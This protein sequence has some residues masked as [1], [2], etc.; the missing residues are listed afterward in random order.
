MV[1]FLFD[2]D[3][4]VTARE[5]LPMIAE[6]YGLMDEVEDLTRLAVMGG[7]PFGE[8]FARRVAVLGRLPVDQVRALVARVPLHELV[9]D[10]ITTH[11]ES[12]AIVTSNLD[13][14]CSGLIGRLGC[15]AHCSEALV[16]HNRVEAIAHILNK[17]DVIEAYQSA[18]DTVVFVGDGHNDRAAMSR[19]DLAVAVGLLPGTPAASLTA[20]A[21]HVFHDEAALCRLLEDVARR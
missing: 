11:H 19:A 12:C 1:R 4:T 8:S 18:G 13:C 6:R 17:E 16:S 15:R 2:L 5:T 14:W 21:S 9:V 20:V 7:I 10:F 3:G